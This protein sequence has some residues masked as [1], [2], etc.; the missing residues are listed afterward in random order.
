MPEFV[1]SLRVNCDPSDNFSSVWEKVIDELVA[2]THRSDWPHG[3]EDQ[4][5]E[6]AVE[7]LR[8][9][10]VG[11][12]NVRHFLALLGEIA[13]TV[14][15]LDEFD[16]LCDPAT[17]SLLANTI[18]TLSDNLV[19]ATL[20]IVGVAD[21]VDELITEHRSVE[22]SVA[23]ILMPRMSRDEIEEIY[24]K[25]FPPLQL[26]VA[27]GLLE[28]LIRLPQGLPYFA[29]R[30]GLEAARCAIRDNRFSLTANDLTHAI[31]V[32]VQGAD[33]SLTSA[34]VNA[35]ASSHKTLFEDVLL[36]CALTPGD[37]MGYF[38]PGDVRN[39]LKRVTG[40]S[41]DIPR[42]AR[43]LVQF[44]SNRGPVL[45]RRG[46]EHRWRYRF[47]NPMMRPYVVMR[48]VDSGVSD[49][50]LETAEPES[51]SDRL[52]EIPSDSEE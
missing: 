20:V 31:S 48:A 16:Q 44:C 4:I 23:Q 35:T 22:R 46:G 27:E 41:I 49:D 18:K 14:V 39:P 5:A 7:L 30:L 25:G 10:E 36:A 8:F 2:A 32:A 19:Q 50:V 13:P 1:I 47:I 17:K 12:E 28:R 40:H 15:F 29:H 24:R 52:F 43:H 11:P 38:A 33:E 6:R 45:E 34:Y 21:N 42:F 3:E 26:E 51:P 37:A 9:D